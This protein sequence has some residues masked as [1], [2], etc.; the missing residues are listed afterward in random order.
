MI[1]KLTLPTILIAALALSGCS[2][3]NQQQRECTI[4]G[5]E[6]VNTTSNTSSAKTHEYRVYTEQ[7]GTLK[8]ADT[9]SYGRWDSSEFYA[10]LKEGETYNLL[11][12]GYRNGFLSMFP[13]ILE[14]EKVE[15]ND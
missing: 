15:T 10:R 11:T 1:K 14:A 13:N 2:T 5:K 6:S 4:T 9:L 12:G 8:V 3:M 7:C